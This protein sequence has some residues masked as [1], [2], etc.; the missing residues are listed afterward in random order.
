MLHSAVDI[1]QA[2]TVSG[3]ETLGPCLL[4]VIGF[5]FDHDSGDGRL[6]DCE[7]APEAAAVAWQDECQVTLMGGP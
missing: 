4:D 3:D 5:V 6:L 2:S 7:C 1:H